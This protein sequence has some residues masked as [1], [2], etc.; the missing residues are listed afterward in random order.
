MLTKTELN[1][2]NLI[3]AINTKVILV[4]AYPMI[5]CK[6]TKEELNKLD[7]DLK[8]KLRMCNMLWRQSSGYRG[9][10]SLR[11]DFIET[12]L[13]VAWC[14]INSSNKWIKVAW[15]RELLKESKD[16][17]IISMHAVST[18]IDFFKEECILLDEERIE[19]D[20]F[21]SENDHAKLVWEL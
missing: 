16:E 20:W 5:V 4:A 7:L 6:F 10:K 9:L 18:A 2:N 1:N 13:G 21:V 8:R 17:A 19:K 15:K 14:I 12:R 11:K 3:K